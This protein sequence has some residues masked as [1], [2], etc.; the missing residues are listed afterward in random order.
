MFAIGGTQLP[1]RVAS[2]IAAAAELELSGNLTQQSGNRGMRPVLTFLAE[3]KQG[4]AVLWPCC[5]D[6]AAQIG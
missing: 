4:H 6:R 1:P 2:G 5:H 3:N